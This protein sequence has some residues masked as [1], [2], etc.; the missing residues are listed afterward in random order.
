M[1]KGHLIQDKKKRK[2]NENKNITR[3]RVWIIYAK[4]D[5]SKRERERL[6]DY[7]TS[8]TKKERKKENE[9]TKP[10]KTKIGKQS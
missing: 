2:R 1:W 10:N 6:S 4:T 7:I 9:K 8:E 5:P 3:K